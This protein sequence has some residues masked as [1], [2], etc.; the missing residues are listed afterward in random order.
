MSRF[1][2]SSTRSYEVTPT[3]PAWSGTV[4]GG[5]DYGVAQTITANFDS[6]CYCELF[7]GFVGDTSHHYDVNIYEY[8]NG[9]NWIARKLDVPVDRDHKWLRF[10]LE[11][12]T[13]QKFVRGK[14]Y[15]VKYTRPGDSAA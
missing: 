4:W 10:D 12:Q 11:T 14:T 7:V 9:A 5:E 6:V 15:I 1:D 8:P 13:G 2:P 3:S